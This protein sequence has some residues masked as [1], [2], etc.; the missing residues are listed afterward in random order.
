MNLRRAG[1]DWPEIARLMGHTSLV[2]TMAHYGPPSEK[3]LVKAMNRHGH[4]E[5]DGPPA[6]RGRSI[7]TA[8]H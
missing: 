6:I 7:P 4:G 2:T 5:D 3:D 8:E 1:T